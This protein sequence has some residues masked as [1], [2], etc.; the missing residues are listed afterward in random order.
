MTS[1]ERSIRIANALGFCSSSIYR[2]PRER[3]QSSK[4]TFNGKR[5]NDDRPNARVALVATTFPFNG[6]RNAANLSESAAYVLFPQPCDVILSSRKW[7]S[8]HQLP[9]RGKICAN[10]AILREL[11]AKRVN[12]PIFDSP[13][14]SGSHRKRMQDQR[15]L[16]SV[17]REHNQS[18]SQ[19]AAAMI[20]QI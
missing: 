13:D 8:R 16:R 14:T 15:R 12:I 2:Y 3:R 9:R 1:R 17:N 20:T 18:H 11:Y 6:T 10:S 19:Y 5:Q 7:R 4:S